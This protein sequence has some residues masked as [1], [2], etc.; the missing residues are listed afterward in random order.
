MHEEHPTTEHIVDYK[1]YAFIWLGLVAFTAI[2]VIAAGINLGPW[3]VFIAL[4]IAS[5]KGLMVMN[6]FMHLKFE[7]R[8]F[9]IFALVAIVILMIF[10]GG[11]MS[12]FITS[13]R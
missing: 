4:G 9:K 8:I 13:A 5:I 3:T 7:D 12:D 2:T 6:V 10:L 1:T 11:T